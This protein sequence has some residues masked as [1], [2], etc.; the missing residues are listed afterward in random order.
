MHGITKIQEYMK[1]FGSGINFHGG[2]GESAP[3]QYIKIPGQRTQRRVS[4]FAQQTAL[5]YYIPVMLHMTVRSD[6]I[7]TNSQE[8]LAQILTVLKQKE[9][10]SWKCQ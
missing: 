5:Q 4:E 10:F 3:K 8:I 6:P 9:M 7:L 2:P 1:I